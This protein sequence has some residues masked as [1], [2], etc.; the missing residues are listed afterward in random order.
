[1]FSSICWKSSINP[2][3][4]SLITTAQ[5]VCG[6]Y[7]TAIPS[8]T[9]LR[10]TT[11][12]TSSVRSMNCP[13]PSV[14]RSWFSNRILIRLPLEAVARPCKTY[15]LYVGGRPSRVEC[16]RRGICPADVCGRPGVR[17]DREAVVVEREADERIDVRRRDARLGAGREADVGQ[18]AAHGPDGPRAVGGAVRRLR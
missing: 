12:T 3:S 14:A 9:W 11:L 2:L 15:H 13:H 7:T 10:S 6:E 5:V 18:Q 1:M 4:R 8:R 16:E 17:A